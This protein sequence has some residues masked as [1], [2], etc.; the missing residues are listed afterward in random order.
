M[1]P[2]STKYPYP[3][4][5]NQ[6][7]KPG[8]EL[9]QK[10]QQEKTM[11]G[12]RWEGIGNAN[13]RPSR[14]EPRLTRNLRKTGHLIGTNPE[15]RGWGGEPRTKPRAGRDTPEPRGRELGKPNPAQ[16]LK[17]PGCEEV[18]GDGEAKVQPGRCKDRQG[19]AKEQGAQQKTSA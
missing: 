13:A 17:G 3:S 2:A 10:Q 14:P 15:T 6:P 7:L 16:E 5:N 11:Q 1:D 4:I 19:E 12:R 9:K 8:H 18:G